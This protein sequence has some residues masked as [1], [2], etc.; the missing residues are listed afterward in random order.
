MVY[1]STKIIYTDIQKTFDSVSHFRLIKTLFQ[2]K[3]H[4]S[5]V[6]WFKEFLDGRTQKLVINKTEYLPVL[7]EY[8]KVGLLVYFYLY[9]YKWYSLEVDV[10]NNINLFADDTKIFG[11]SNKI[12]QPSL[13]K[14]YHWLK[15]RK[16]NLN[17]A[18]CYVLNIH[19]N[20][21]NFSDFKINNTKLLLTRLFKDL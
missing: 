16:L 15:D 19:K 9:L 8:L 6:N 14:I 12:L 2:Y 17:P 18:K 21:H 7:V 4:N 3:I 20:N 5:L 1:K 11:Q 10:R 13:D